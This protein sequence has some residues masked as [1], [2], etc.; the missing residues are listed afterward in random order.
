MGAKKQ[1]RMKPGKTLAE[2]FGWNAEEQTR[3]ELASLQ[4]RLTVL[5]DRVSILEAAQKQRPFVDPLIKN[6]KRP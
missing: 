2:V 4:A 5:E 6:R 3:H 1:A